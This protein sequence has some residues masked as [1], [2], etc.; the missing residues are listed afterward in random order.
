MRAYSI[1]ASGSN[2]VVLQTA[3]AGIRFSVE[4]D[5]VDIKEQ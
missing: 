1:Y 3:F 5:W 2:A 4:M